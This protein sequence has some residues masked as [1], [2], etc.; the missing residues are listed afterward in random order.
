MSWI[1]FATASAALW[2]LSYVLSEKML[3]TISAVSLMLYTSFGSIFIFIIL[4]LYKGDVSRDWEILKKGGIELKYIAILIL[5]EALASLSILYSIKEKNATSAGLI[6]ISYP[7]FAALFA[8]LIFKDNQL[9]VGTIIGGIL[10]FSGVLC[11][12]YFNK[13][14]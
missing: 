9:S 3:E 7:L 2:G 12:A 5:V 8:W 13:T 4:A 6:E 10:I 1:L 11:I 14:V